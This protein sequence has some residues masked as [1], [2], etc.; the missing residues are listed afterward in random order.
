MLLQQGP[1]IFHERAAA[2]HIHFK[3][4]RL[5]LLEREAAIAADGLIPPLLRKPQVVH[6]V[7]GFMHRAQQSAERVDQIEARSDS[8]VSRHTLGKRVFAFVQAAA[9]ERKTERLEHLDR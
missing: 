5:A 6:R 1:Q 2:A 8:N 9:V 7:A 4:Q 3:Q